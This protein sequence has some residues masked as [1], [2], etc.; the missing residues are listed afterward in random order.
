MWRRSFLFFAL[1]ST[2][3]AAT[4][5][6]M[7]ELAVP[8]S[9]TPA[10]DRATVVFIR[11]S[12]YASSLVVTI[13]DT[14]GRFVGDALPSS[15]FVARVEPGEHTFI[16]WA[17]NTS[18]LYATLQPGKVYFVEVE[19]KLGALSARAHLKALTPR[20][21]SWADRDGWLADA[22]ELEV[23]EASGQAYLESRREDVEERIRRAKEALEK[24]SPAEL[25]ERTLLP[26][27]G[28]VP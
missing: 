23:D 24:Y 13:L 9:P 15:Y 22:R 27:D 12:S 7:T 2:G 5:E 16:G 21:E 3:C 20:G 6:F 28:V 19:L 8:R 25:A 11:P 1:A 26:N 4:S 10:S 18:A 14:E 17:E